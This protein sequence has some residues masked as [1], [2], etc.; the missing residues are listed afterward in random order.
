MRII[1][2]TEMKSV[3]LKN[4]CNKLEKEICGYRLVT[5]FIQKILASFQGTVMWVDVC[6]Q[7]VSMVI[8]SGRRLALAG[9]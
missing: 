6:K 5:A 9:N 1:S 3:H 8:K 7:E 4:K 2:V